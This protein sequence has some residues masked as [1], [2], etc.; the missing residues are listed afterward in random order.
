[1]DEKK[2]AQA[3]IAALVAEAKA[4]IKEAEAIADQ[5]GLMFDFSLGYGMGGTYTGETV[6]DWESSTQGEWQS[7][8]SMC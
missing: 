4:K 6:D 2:Q 3:Q 5:H 8:S 7:S 1:M